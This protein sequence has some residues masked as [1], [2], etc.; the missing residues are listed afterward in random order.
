MSTPYIIARGDH[1]ASVDILVVGGGLAGLYLA[2][3][4]AATYPV[5]VLVIEAGPDAGPDHLRWEHDQKKANQLWLE[6]ESDPFFS[7]PYHAAGTGFDGIS[8][9]RRRLGGRALYWGGVTLPVEPWALEPASWPP[10]VI[11]ELTDAWQG[12]PSLYD[13]VVAD[14]E[15]WMGGPLTSEREFQLGDRRFTEVPRAVLAAG[16]SPRWRAWSP[17]EL[18]PGEQQPGTVS[19]LCDHQVVAVTSGPDGAVSGVVAE[20]DGRRTVIEARRVV[21][22]AGTIEN[23]R[24]VLQAVTPADAQPAVLPGLVDKLAQ[25][26]VTAFDPAAVP[27]AIRELADAG[28]LFRAA[29]PPKSRSNL[30]LSA[31]R[32]GHGLVVVDC[33]LMG[34]Q[35]RDPG[36]Q[37]WCE[38]GPELPWR[39]SV[40]G[41]LGDADR[42]VIAAQRQEL[43]RMYQLLDEQAGLTGRPLDFE[44][45]GATDLADWV[46]AGDA[47][48]TPGRPVTYSFPLGSEQHE[49]GTLPLGGTLVDEKAQVRAVPGLYVCGPAT[50]P[51][52]GAANPAL[53]ILALAARLAGEFTEVSR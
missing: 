45:F 53:T 31:H 46:A 34:E 16:N 48:D 4:I 27:D 51:R 2:H 1:P 49:A 33:Y 42:E 10:E 36:G 47:M 9:L 18:R 23:S 17:L 13:R 25:G 21:L 28:G 39:T 26:F 44:P 24:L 19:V 37:V 50:F 38:P 32:N 35:A 12:G 43:R 7:Q 8:G 20:N 40:A 15:R 22:A 14:L 5:A 52:T 29:A 11:A 3:R 6:P 30:M 41:R